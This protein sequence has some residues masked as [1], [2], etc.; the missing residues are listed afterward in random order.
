MKI[1]SFSINQHWYLKHTWSDKAF[2]GTVVN[3]ALPSLYGGSVEIALTVFRP[4]WKLRPWDRFQGLDQ[5]KRSSLRSI[6]SQGWVGILMQWRQLFYL[7]W[8]PTSIFQITSL[9]VSIKRI[10]KW[11]LLF[12][13]ICM[14]SQAWLKAWD[15]KSEIYSRLHCIDIYDYDCT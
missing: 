2:K 7:G 11:L 13:S 6:L 3:R 4:N 10:C 15:I 5:W 14:F 12:V 1:N 9:R 8:I